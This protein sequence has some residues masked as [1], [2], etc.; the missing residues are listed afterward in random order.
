MLRRKAGLKRAH[1]DLQLDRVGL[2]GVLLLTNEK[3]GGG[4]LKESSISHTYS[5]EFSISVVVETE[6]QNQTF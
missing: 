3:G 1:E 4:S 2:S 5:D 6:R